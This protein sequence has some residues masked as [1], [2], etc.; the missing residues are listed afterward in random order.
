MQSFGIRSMKPPKTY[1]QRIDN[2]T[3]IGRFLPF[4]KATKAL[5]VSRGI[6]LHFLGPR[7]TRWGGQPHV[8]AACTPG[9]EPVP[10]LREA[11]WASGPVWT[12]G[13][14]RLH[15]DSIPDRPA[16]TQSLYRLS[17]PAN[18][19]TYI[20]KINTGEILKWGDWRRIEKILWKDRVKI[21]VLDRVKVERD[22]LYT[23]RRCKASWIGHILCKNCLLKHVIAW[24]IEVTGRR[25]RRGKQLLDDLKET[26]GNWKRKHWIALCGGLALDEA[27][28]LS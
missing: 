11:G 5:R 27:V 4:L 28:G 23:I 17:Y 9:K 8:P 3:Y 10:V 2:S 13:K 26:T 19:N 25:G 7:H 18:N 14:S 16:R 15:R 21:D 20:K 22:I 24:R 6:A 1:Y 12:G